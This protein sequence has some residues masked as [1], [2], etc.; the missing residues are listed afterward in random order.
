MTL[1]IV[2]VSE[3]EVGRPGLPGR[4]A[5]GAVRLYQGARGGRPSGCRFLPSCSEYA[6]EA[7]E[8]HGVIRGGTL[9]ARRIGRCRPL[10]GRG[11][12]P[13]PEVS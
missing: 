1:E 4:L 9:A 10:G 8:T 12:D 13:V 2:T 6:I 7:I 11:Y 3:T 5:A